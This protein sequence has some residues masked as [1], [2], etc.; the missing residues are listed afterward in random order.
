MTRIV[1]LSVQ[2]VAGAH[3]LPPPAKRETK[4]SQYRMA[5]SIH[6]QGSY[7]ETT[8]HVG[9]HVD[10]P[11]HV[12]SDGAP[13][14][15]IGLDRFMG[16]AV[17]IDLTPTQPNSAIDEHI[18][19]R[20]AGKIRHGDIAI[21]RTDWTDVAWGTARYWADSPFL[22]GGGARWLA[23]QRPKAVAFDFFE[24][25]CARF[26]SFKAEEFVVHLAL[27]KDNDILLIENITNIGALRA[28]RVQLFA[29]PVKIMAAEGAPAR[30]FALDP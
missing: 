14:G 11:L 27:L 29:A 17:V 30:V 1:D 20:H 13:I 18:L 25:Y 10:S 28:E 24:E 3:T 7:I 9:S 16:E 2:V 15:T 21:L 19:A 4:I 6:W 5:G 26:E 22:T 12:A 8:T 23:A